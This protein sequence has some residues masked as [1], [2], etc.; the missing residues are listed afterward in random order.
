MLPVHAKVETMKDTTIEKYFFNENFPGEEL[1]M[2]IFAD[3]S[4][5]VPPSGKPDFTTYKKLKNRINKLKRKSK[6]PDSKKL[7]RPL[8]NGHDLMKELKLK[9]GPPIGKLLAIA[10]ETQLSGKIKTK[11]QAL[12]FLKKQ[13]RD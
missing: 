2:L 6:G 9:S 12:T 10:R 8:I 11:K 7:P 1:L 13:N 3:I 4:A 5:T